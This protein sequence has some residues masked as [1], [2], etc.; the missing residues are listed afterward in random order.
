MY[1][2]ANTLEHCPSI[3]HYTGKLE[4]TLLVASVSSSDSRMGAMASGK[5]ALAS[6]TTTLLISAGVDTSLGNK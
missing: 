1:E 6:G 3:T 4:G 5:V 2:Y